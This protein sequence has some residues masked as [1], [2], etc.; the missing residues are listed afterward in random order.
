MNAALRLWDRGYRFRL[1]SHDE[2]A[3]IVKDEDVDS[4]KAVV[5]EELRRPPSW[6]RDLPLD[7][8]A[9]VGQSYGDAK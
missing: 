5:L 7:A 9:G 4:A 8:E 2:L 3:F 1:Q 6:A